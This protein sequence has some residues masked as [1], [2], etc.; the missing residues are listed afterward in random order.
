MRTDTHCR[1]MSLDSE[2]ATSRR[3]RGATASPTCAWCGA[4]LLPDPADRSGTELCSA[5]G[6]RTTWPMPTDAELELAYGTWYR[7]TEGRFAGL[8]DGALRRSRGRLARRLDRIAPAGPVL[9]VGAGDGALLDGLAAVGREAVGLER[10]ST[11]ADVRE[12]G[13]DEI[14]GRFAAV[15]FWHSLEHL[16]A[17]G[18]ALAH[19]ARLLAPGG[20]LVV[21][22]PNLASLQAR[23][24]GERWFAV[25]LPRHLVH[26]PAPA[27]L[28]RIR[29]L[30]LQPTRVSY[31]RGGQVVFGWLHGLVG[32][33]PGRPDLY[34]AIRR[35]QARRTPMSAGKRIAILAA[36][37]I[38]LP[39]AG[40][41]ALL[42][43]SLRRGGTVYVEARLG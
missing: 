16:R 42:E 43:A 8:A 10:H 28:A 9:D 1:T 21:A 18:E 26:V 38:A 22:I 11:R 14:D 30:G 15:V 36:G 13:I 39:A 41:C 27:L 32:S 23:A 40:A 4:T 7:P 12:A 29:E 19:A 33:L 24:F 34:D 25:D 6:A 5:C 3:P 20:V 31:L 37:A 2:T 17:A 35:P